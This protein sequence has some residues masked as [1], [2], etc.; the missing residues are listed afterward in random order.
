MNT[1][2]LV[3]KEKEREREREQYSLGLLLPMS[4]PPGFWVCSGHCRN[5]FKLPNTVAYAAWVAGEILHACRIAFTKSYELLSSPSE[6]CSKKSLVASRLLRLSIIGAADSRTYTYK[7]KSRIIY[8][9]IRC[10]NIMRINKLGTLT[11]TC[12]S[13][14]SG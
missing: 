3:R 11:K 13:S 5:C 6:N 12:S 1:D 7:E 9:S 10:R 14:K 4:L 2:N 8:F